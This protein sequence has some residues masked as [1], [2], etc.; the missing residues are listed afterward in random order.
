MAKIRVIKGGS[1]GVLI[2]EKKLGESG[3]VLAK[4]KKYKNK[5]VFFKVM[6]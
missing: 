3:Q 6:S 4:G 1:A 5:L 2:K